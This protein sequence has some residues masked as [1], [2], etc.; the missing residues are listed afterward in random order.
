MIET[1]VLLVKQNVRMRTGI[2]IPSMEWL[3]SILFHTMQLVMTKYMT[4]VY[5]HMVKCVLRLLLAWYLA[6]CA[7]RA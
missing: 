4:S 1:A 7:L 5:T 3:R 2:D 6:D